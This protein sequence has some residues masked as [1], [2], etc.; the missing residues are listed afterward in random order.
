MLK[1]CFLLLLLVQEHDA[2]RSGRNGR[3]CTV[4]RQ[5][6]ALPLAEEGRSSSDPPKKRLISPNDLNSLFG[7]G[8]S[9]SSGGSNNNKKGGRALYSEEE[10]EE[11]DVVGEAVEASEEDAFVEEE[12]DG[13]EENDA[14]VEKNGINNNQRSSSS[15]SSSSSGSNGPSSFPETRDSA[16]SVV[17]EDVSMQSLR[18]LA[19]LEKMLKTPSPATDAPKEEEVLSSE[20]GEASVVVAAGGG[21]EQDEDDEYVSLTS[22]LNKRQKRTVLS[23]LSINSKSTR[24]G[25]VRI[26][27]DGNVKQAASEVRNTRYD[28]SDVYRGDPMKYG[29]YR[30][31]K[32]VDDEIASEG[33]KGGK[34]GG[35]KKKKGGPGAG[36]K[37]KSK[38]ADTNPQSPNSFL[39]AI[40]KLGAFGNVV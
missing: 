18:E 37:I 39:N 33:A 9:S 8:S 36:K 14:V 19:M 38:G 29:A 21:E 34:K 35:V 2:L 1:T 30:R 20:G 15:S 32:I 17:V 10:E 16:A 27:F 25:S 7:G 40:K 4:S 11:D 28:P 13:E 5:K 24:S 26:G 6:S 31:W 23:D 3:S 12:D 22:T